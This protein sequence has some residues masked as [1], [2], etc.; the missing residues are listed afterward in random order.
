MS[1]ETGH[2]A[3]GYFKNGPDVEGLHILRDAV[4]G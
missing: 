4:F 3:S 2:K 1:V